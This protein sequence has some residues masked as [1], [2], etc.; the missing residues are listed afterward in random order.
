[1]T[2]KNRKEIR[3]L[4]NN[5]YIFTYQRSKKRIRVLLKEIL[6]TLRYV[7]EKRKTD[8]RVDLFV[9]VLQFFGIVLILLSLLAA[10][11][12]FQVGNR[13]DDNVYIVN[14]PKGYSVNQVGDL[15]AERGVID[16][17]YGFNLIVGLFGLEDKIQAGIY[18]FTPNMSLLKIILRIKNGEVIP[19]LL[20][21]IVFPEGISIYK[22]GNLL[23]KEGLSDGI[24]FRNLTN[25][26]I[27]PYLRSKYRFLKDV[28]T[29]SLEGYLFPDTYLIQS[30]ISASVLADL[31]LARF[32]QVIMPYW[33]KNARNTKYSLHEILTL[34]SIIEKEAAVPSERKLISSVF[35][36]RLK[37]RMYLG[38]DP[39]IKYALERPH[40]LVSYDDLEVNSPY[41]TYKRFGLP[42]GPICSPGLDSIKAAIYPA[43]TDYIYFVA[44]A[45]GSHIFSRTWEEHEAAKKLTRNERIKKIYKR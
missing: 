4:L 41:N 15:L 18:E 1:M 8:Q 5:P 34:A 7:Q 42:P 17:K 37:I 27:T 36:N 39:T 40:K 10:C 11:V 29:N 19:P 25:N 13:F 45:D 31:M 9:Y 23:I 28:P 26:A 3:K 6:R 14:I 43:K 32:N 21:K 22:M 35:H 16:G 24:A 38:A 30:N 2:K 20:S 33:R 44:R 12:F